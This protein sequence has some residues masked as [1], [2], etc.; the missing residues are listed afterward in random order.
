MGTFLSEKAKND[1]LKE[2]L[3]LHL[4]TIFHGQNDVLKHKKTRLI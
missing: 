1:C 4:S 2:V 3:N